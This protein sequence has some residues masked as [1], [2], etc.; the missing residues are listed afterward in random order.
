MYV[1]E[2]RIQDPL[3]YHVYHPE[4]YS[5]PCKTYMM[6]LSCKNSHWQD[7]KYASIIK[8]LQELIL[9]NRQEVPRFTR[10]TL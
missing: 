5:K 2:R 6:E 9:N 8:V 3:K 7:F 4:A 10:S 1:A